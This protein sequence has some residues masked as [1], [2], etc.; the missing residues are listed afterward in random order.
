MATSPCFSHFDQHALALEQLC[1]EGEGDGTGT[2]EFAEQ[3]RTVV[4]EVGGG[5][6]GG[7][8]G[9]L[10]PRV[11]KV[12]SLFLFW[13]WIQYKVDEG[14]TLQTATRIT[15]SDRLVRF[16]LVFQRQYGYGPR[17]HAF[18]LGYKI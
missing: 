17:R 16:L 10:V 2:A 18:Q 8:P 6:P 13:G 14:A 5:S 7:F 12:L 15:K 1:G 4:E 11:R 9:A 3:A